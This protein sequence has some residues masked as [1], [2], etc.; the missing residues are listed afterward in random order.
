MLHVPFFPECTASRVVLMA[1]ALL[2][3]PFSPEASGFARGFYSLRAGGRLCVREL[4]VLVLVLSPLRDHPT[5]RFCSEERT[6][7]KRNTFPRNF[8]AKVT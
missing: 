8:F 7:C 3:W 6:E 4:P 5:F 1:K 2:D